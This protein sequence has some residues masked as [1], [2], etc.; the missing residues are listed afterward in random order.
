MADNQ[1]GRRKGAG[2][3]KGSP[4]KSTARA[5]ETIAQF[6]EG[7]ADRLNG[8]LDKIEKEN[9]ELEAFKAFTT[10]LEYHVPKLARS[11]ITGKG[12]K[13]L[14]PTTIQIVAGS[15]DSKG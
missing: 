15:E 1:G 11:E 9:G 2:R 4:N 6:V 5:R 12:G 13:D 14:A 7:N 8:W 10:L 3:P